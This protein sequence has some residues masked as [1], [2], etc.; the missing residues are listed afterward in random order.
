MTTDLVFRAEK[1]LFVDVLIGVKD[2]LGAHAVDVTLQ[3]RR[4]G[5]EEEEFSPEALRE[6]SLLILGGSVS[7]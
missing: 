5:L 3:T 2:I 7:K 6:L 4:V 1:K